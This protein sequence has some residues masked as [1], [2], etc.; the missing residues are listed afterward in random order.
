VERTLLP[1]PERSEL[2]SR[3][4]DKRDLAQRC[5][6][7]LRAGASEAATSLLTQYAMELEERAEMLDALAT[8]DMNPRS[9]VA[10]RKRNGPRP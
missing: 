7:A 10:A 1:T 5:R 2:Q 6:N 3:A 9:G 4:R 8:A